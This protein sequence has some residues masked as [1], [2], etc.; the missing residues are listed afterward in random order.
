MAYNEET[1]MWEGWIYKIVNNV[2]DKVYIGQTR[3]NLETRFKQHKKYST[4]LDDKHSFQIHR[5]M[6]KYGLDNFKIIELDKVESDN[7]KNLKNVLDKKEIYYISL[8]DSYKNGY[9]ATLGGE[10][11][12]CKSI[13]LYSYDGDVV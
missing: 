9:N 8:Y 4:K 12:D 6:H 11:V 3:L 10:G 7:K 5:A 1:G 2:N 13:T